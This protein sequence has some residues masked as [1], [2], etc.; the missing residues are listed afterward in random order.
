MVKSLKNMKK[1]SVSQKVILIQLLFE[2]DA[3][4]LS[5]SKSQTDS[6]S[7]YR[8]RSD[9]VESDR[10]LPSGRLMSEI[11]RTSTICHSSFSQAGLWATNHSCACTQVPV[12]YSEIDLPNRFQSIFFHRSADNVNIMTFSVNH[13]H[14]SFSIQMPAG[15]VAMIRIWGGSS[16]LADDRN[17]EG[18]ADVR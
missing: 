16:R 15:I 11:T 8:R 12:L 4:W 5:F 7:L 17:P 2:K 10:Y 3:V 13:R 18:D 1:I 6:P 9:S 14:R